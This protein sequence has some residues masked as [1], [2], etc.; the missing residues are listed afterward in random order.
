MSRKRKGRDVSGWLSLDKPI[1]RTSTDMVGAV[2]RLFAAAKVGHAGTLDPLASGVLP[3]AFGEAT[4]TVSFVQDSRKIYRFTVRWGVETDTD[5]AEGQATAT[6][7]ARPDASAIAAA[8]PEFTGDIRQAPPAYSAVKIDGNRAYDLARAGEPV[9]TEER[10]VTIHRLVLIDTPDRDHAILEAECGK[11]TYVRAL[12]R[13]LGRR[14]GTRAHVAALR[15]LLVGPFDEASLVRFDALIAAREEGDAASLDRFLKPIGFA[16]GDLPEIR[17]AEREAASLRR[18]QAVLLRGRDAPI[19]T[20]MAHA[21]FAGESLA[22]GEVA[23][24][25]FHPHRVFNG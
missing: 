22:V 3:I 11:G 1:G 2:K 5:D 10:T 23:E 14:L 13:D 12:A 15:R 21:T 8:L 4:K 6:S 16:L 9:T 17:V 20:G 7:E 25:Q 19:L 24:G 18:G